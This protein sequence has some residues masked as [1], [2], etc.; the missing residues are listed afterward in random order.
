MAWL[1]WFVM[2]CGGPLP[3]GAAVPLPDG[4]PPVDRAMVVDEALADAVEPVLS[5]YLDRAGLPGL[6]VALVAQGEVRYAAGIGWAEIETGEPWLVGTPVLVSSVAKTVVGT[7]AMRA[8]EVEGLDLD[9]PVATYL[10][11]PVNPGAEPTLRHV[12]NHRGTLGN[13]VGYANAYVEGDAGQS[14]QDFVQGYVD[15]RVERFEDDDVTPREPGE[16][17]AYSNTGISLA[18]VAVVRGGDFSERART[19][20]F[21][22]LGMSG[23]S[24]FVDGRTEPTVT[25]YASFG[26]RLRP[27]PA[28]GHPSWPERML[29]SSVE[30]MGRYLGGITGGGTFEGT[31]LLTAE[32]VDE[33]L[34][35]VPPGD[36]ELTA[37]LGWLGIERR[38]RALVGHR[39]ADFGVAAALWVDRDRDVGVFVVTNG[40]P[41]IEADW[42]ALQ[43]D[44]LDLVE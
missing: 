18:A 21:E 24:Y 30:E 29:R 11:Y 37:A 12:L 31:T 27:Y 7:V 43:D 6:G 40:R 26:R 8:V 13:P 44:L 15:A 10:G 23:T 3:L 39:G 19:L 35:V 20:L 28:Y 17:F 36:E 14:V 22:P 9:E 33:L 41:S 4:P 1:G 5:D 32:H 2:A 16:T 38:G 42:E 34:T 25:L